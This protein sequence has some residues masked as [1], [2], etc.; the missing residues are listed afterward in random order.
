VGK[1][2]KRSRIESAI[3]ARGADV[4][5]GFLLPHL[6]PDMVILDCGCGEATIT[7]GLAQHIQPSAA[8]CLS[9]HSSDLPDRMPLRNGAA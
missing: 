6:R 9:L 3:E 5:G 8:S 1:A 4:Y 2:Q 7:M